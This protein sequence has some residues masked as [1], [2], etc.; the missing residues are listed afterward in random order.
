MPKPSYPKYFKE[1]PKPKAHA[2]KVKD[3][4]PTY[5][6]IYQPKATTTVKQNDHNIPNNE[7]KPLSFHIQNTT[8]NLLKEEEKAYEVLITD[9]KFFP[10]NITV[11]TNSVVSWKVDKNET[12][13]DSCVYDLEA[14]SFV[15]LIHDKEIVESDL[16]SKDQIFTHKFKRPGVYRVQCANYKEIQGYVEVSDHPEDKKLEKE[17]ESLRYIER[18]PESKRNI[19]AKNTPEMKDSLLLIKDFECEGIKELILELSLKSASDKGTRGRKLSSEDEVIEDIQEHSRRYERA[20]SEIRNQG[21]INIYDSLISREFNGIKIRSR[22]QSIKSEKKEKVQ[23]K[24]NIFLKEEIRDF[25][26]GNEEEENV[27]RELNFDV[28][29][30]IVEERFKLFKS[31]ILVSIKNP[32]D[33]EQKF[34]LALNHSQECI[35][36]H[37]EVNEE[38]S[39]EIEEPKE[40]QLLAFLKQ[41]IKIPVENL[42][43][44]L[45]KSNHKKR[46]GSYKASNQE[47]D[48]ISALKA[49]L[50]NSKK[51]I[52]FEIYN[53]F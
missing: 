25:S 1:K 11:A 8:S 29:K 22:D 33:E 27:I 35:I 24:K 5:I 53:F 21:E 12:V 10:Q 9:F 30:K 17:Q 48:R 3:R 42:K 51:I 16:L 46:R 41:E 18:S 32:R 47:V 52:I 15:I 31:P 13:H 45:A 4:H 49:F 44:K 26:V 6:S 28:P 38:E 2:S 36:I 7:S 43:K 37:N 50:A 34:D 40:D 20:T 14:R 39:E 19:S 23:E